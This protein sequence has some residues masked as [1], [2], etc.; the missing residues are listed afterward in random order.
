MTAGGR[1]GRPHRTA[2]LNLTSLPERRTSI[3]PVTSPRTNRPACATFT[4]VAGHRGTM[5]RRGRPHVARRI[6]VATS[7]ISL[8]SL[9]IAFPSRVAGANQK[10]ARSALVPQAGG[11]PRAIPTRNTSDTSAF[12]CARGTNIGDAPVECTG[13][14]RRHGGFDRRDPRVAGFP[15][16]RWNPRCG[17][18][19]PRRPPRR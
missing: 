11:P 10:P 13:R 1:G 19:L 18:P 14:G 6:C 9:R 15:L 12:L 16:I 2:K 3:R 5:P 17:A 8:S 7:A 4:S